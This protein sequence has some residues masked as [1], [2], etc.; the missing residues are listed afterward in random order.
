MQTLPDLSKWK[1]LP[2]LQDKARAFL[3][4]AADKGFS[5]RITQGLRTM[6][7]QA[8]LYAQGRTTP[9]KIVTHAK[10]G[11]SKHNFGKAFDVCFTGKDP[12]PTDDKKWKD[13][14]DIGNS[15]GLT[16]G[17]YFKSF[18]DKPHFQI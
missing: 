12:Y 14:A 8:K 4:T 17:Y 10:P 18:Q 2:E 15:L 9:G 5:L 3:T 6:E 13:I 7:E 1:L 16:P 11:E